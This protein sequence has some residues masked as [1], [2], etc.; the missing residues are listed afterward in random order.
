MD[1]EFLDNVNDFLF[2][3]RCTVEQPFRL[4]I[5]VDLPGDAD[6]VVGGVPAEGE[7]DVAGVLPPLDEGLDAGGPA[8]DGRV[9]GEG[10]GDGADEGALAGA[11]GADDEVEARAGAAD[12]AVVGHEVAELDLDDVARHVVVVPSQGR[13]GGGGGGDLG[14]LGGAGGRHGWGGVG[15]GAA[16]E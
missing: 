8:E 11:V 3:D 16:A 4:V 12:E 7:L 5:A 1:I 13:G 14:A 6:V 2:G 15:W 9:G 10:E